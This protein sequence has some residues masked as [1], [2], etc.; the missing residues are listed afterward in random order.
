[1]SRISTGA[2]RQKVSGA[3]SVKAAASKK[4]TDYSPKLGDGADRYQMI[5][6]AAYYRAEHR[7]FSGGNPVD[8][9]LAAEAEIDRLYH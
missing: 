8:D 7:G 5:A 2:S 3:S 6:T 1:M 4:K 9:W